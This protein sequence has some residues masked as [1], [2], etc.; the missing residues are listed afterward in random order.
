[1]EYFDIW[2]YDSSVGLVTSF[3]TGRLGNVLDSHFLLTSTPAFGVISGYRELFLR[4]KA[5]HLH[6]VWRFSLC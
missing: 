5:T 4:G 6:L 3:R 2:R 1:M